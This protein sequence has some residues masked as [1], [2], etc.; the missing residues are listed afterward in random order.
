[1]ANWKRW[2]TLFLCAA[3]ASLLAL[4]VPVAPFYQPIIAVL[5]FAV[6]ARLLKVG[7][8]TATLVFAL[9]LSSAPIVM[10][11]VVAAAS[12][13]MHLYEAFYWSIISI[14]R[15]SGLVAFFLLPIA[16]ALATY[17]GRPWLYP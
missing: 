9:L 3:A 1:M 14:S 4:L 11:S 7:S 6:L 17:A 16:L 5:L 10:F 8:F 2:I 12:S 15:L 13:D